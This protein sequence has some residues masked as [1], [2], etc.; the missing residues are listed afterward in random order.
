MMKVKSVKYNF[1]MNIILT[2][3][4]FIFP[5]ITSRYISPIL[6][7]DGVGKVNLATSIAQ[8]FTMV[9][10]LGVPTYGIRACAGDSFAESPDFHLSV[11]G[12][13][14]CCLECTEDA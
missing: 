12:L 8:Y 9:A 5:L 2:A 13:F 10:M 14:H 6:L 1:I 4:T 3:S 11:C 7:P